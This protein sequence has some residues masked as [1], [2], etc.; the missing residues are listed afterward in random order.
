MRK[1]II[2]VLAASVVLFAGPATAQIVTAFPFQLQ[3]NTLADATQ[4]MANFNQLRNNVNSNAAKNGANSD[5]TS[6]LGLTT[7]LAPSVGGSTTWTGG[8]STGSANAQVVAS[9]V[10]SVFSQVAGTR[11]VFKAG[12]S[13]SGPMTLLVAGT[14][15]KLVGR[16]TSNIGLQATVGG[17]VFADEMVEVVYDGTIY[18]IVGVRQTVGAI[19]DYAGST[20]PAGK[21]FANGTCISQTTYAALFAVTGTQWGSCG[22]GLFALPDLRGRNTI[23]PDDGANRVTN[24]GSGCTATFTTACGAQNQSFTVAKV[25]LTAFTLD[26]TLGI[27]N[28]MGLTNTLG[29]NNTMGVS[30]SRTWATSNSLF[31]AGAAQGFAAGASVGIT[32]AAQ[33]VTTTGGSLGLTGGTALTGGVALTGGTALTGSVTSGGSSTAIVVTTLAPTIVVSKVIQ[34]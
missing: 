16:Q 1:F 22:A 25:N 21:L 3:N 20:A 19:T 4:V 2:G 5:I 23:A 6:L 15:A 7:P 27:T 29:I 8:T 9:V 30:D 31:P 28:T 14:G 24:A 34:Y 18:Q 17:E 33:A 13:N 11:V 32:A 10:P 12:F 26:N